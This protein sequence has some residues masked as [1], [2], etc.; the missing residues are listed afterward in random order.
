MIQELAE[1][2]NKMINYQPC[3]MCSVIGQGLT[4]EKEA[5]EKGTDPDMQKYT[6]ASAIVQDSL[7][8]RILGNFIIMVQRPTV[9]TK[10]FT[11]TADALKWFDELRKENSQR[12]PT[13]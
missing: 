12:K 11:S 13:R 7:A 4:I 3:F 9:P 8:H 5:R 10:L 2:N 6:L 1:H